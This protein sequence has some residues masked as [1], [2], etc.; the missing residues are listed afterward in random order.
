MGNHT[1]AHPHT[2]TGLRWAAGAAALGLAS[3]GAGLVFAPGAAWGAVLACFLFWTGAAQGGPLLASAFH[4]T[5]ARWGRVVQRFSEVL[6]ILLPLTLLGPPLL[7]L[8][9]P[10]LFPELVPGRLLRDEAALA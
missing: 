10:H 5:E 2:H 1:A 8:G 9:R 4:I 6:G 3:F 7:W